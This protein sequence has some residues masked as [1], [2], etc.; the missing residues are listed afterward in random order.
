MPEFR[1]DPITGKWVI[2][3]TERA[4]RP[5]NF[6]DKHKQE[7]R[8]ERSRP[9]C[10]FCVG[11]ET[12]TPPEV[13][14]IRTEGTG[15]DSPGW[16]VRTVPNKFPALVPEGDVER[17]GG[18]LYA[19]MAGIGVHEVIVETPA[20]DLSPGQL[21]TEEV[22]D[23]VRAYRDR[24]RSL[25]M[26][27][28]LRY[29]LIFRNHGRTAGASLEHPHSQLIATPVLPPV[30]S[31]ELS[32]AKDYYDRTGHCV[33]CHM[34]EEELVNGDRVV[35]ENDRFVAF[36]PFASRTPF[37]TWIV[38]KAHSPSFGDISEDE[39]P[40]FAE[41]MRFVLSRMHDGLNDPAYNYLIHTAPVGEPNGYDCYAHWHVE[42]IPK[43]AIAAGFEL[44]T[45][46]YINVATPEDTARF[47]R[48][49]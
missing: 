10:P 38:P 49:S 21:G 37:E 35:F 13:H 29:I 42:I 40:E 12:L 24:F 4:K 22:E 31:E 14:C 43:L 7:A 36:E 18:G 9:D 8:K 34:V 5:E 28:R 25:A 30:V 15:P 17:A 39:I 23:I 1:R 41:A 19:T 11:N 27:N 46:I 44:G 26:D 16:C 20:H 47:L 32:G 33:Y 3:A 45:G 6:S 48:E 2:V